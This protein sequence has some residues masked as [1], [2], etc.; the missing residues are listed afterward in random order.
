[1][2]SLC[3]CNVNIPQIVVSLHLVSRVLK[4]LILTIFPG[5]GYFVGEQMHRAPQSDDL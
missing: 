1:M 4:K 2:L 3:K 5:S